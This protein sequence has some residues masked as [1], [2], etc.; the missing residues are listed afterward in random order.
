LDYFT[1]VPIPIF[2]PQKCSSCSH[3]GKI[4]RVPGD[5]QVIVISNEGK[6]KALKVHLITFLL[7]PLFL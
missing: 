1:G 4:K 5:H 6:K 7:I 2:A 3:F